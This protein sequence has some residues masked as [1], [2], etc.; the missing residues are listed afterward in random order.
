MVEWLLSG[1][2]LLA[3]LVP[4]TG[5]ETPDFD[6]ERFGDGFWGQPINSVTSLAFVAAGMAIAKQADRSPR[7][8]Y[9]SLVGATGIGSVVQ[10]GPNPSWADLAHDL[11]LVALIAFVAADATAD[12]TGRHLPSVW[13][14][15]PSLVL[16]PVILM[17]PGAADAAQVVLAAVAIG[18]SLLRVRL[19][20]AWR[21]TILTSMALLA[22]GGTLGTLSRSGWPWCRPDS[23]VQGHAVWHVLAAAALWLLTPAIGHIGQR[24]GSA[25]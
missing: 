3:R 25:S 10:H 18:M 16:V 1:D 9:A 12:V 17:A 11:P 8:V 19:R 4:F 20:P 14:V 15:A 5:A 22:V 23:L 13:W 7:L 6:C 2:R 21:R 24:V